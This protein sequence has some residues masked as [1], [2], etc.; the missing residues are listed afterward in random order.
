MALLAVRSAIPLLRDGALGA[1]AL[2]RFAY[3]RHFAAVM[4]SHWSRPVD[5][6][7]INTQLQLRYISSTPPKLHCFLSI[8]QILYYVVQKYVR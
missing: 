6:I 4:I 3:W 2:M 8:L 1:P 5:L 7:E